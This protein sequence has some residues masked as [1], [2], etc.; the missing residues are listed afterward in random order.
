MLPP[1]TDAIH[2]YIKREH[3]QS[4]VLKQANCPVQSLVVLT[5]IGWVHDGKG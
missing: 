4:M 1:A 3:Y 5:D 2:I